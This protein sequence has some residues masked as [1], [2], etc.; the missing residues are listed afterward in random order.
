MKKTAELKTLGVDDYF[1]MQDEGKLRWSV[2]LGIFSSEDAAKNRLEALRA[3]GVRSAQLGERET[4]VAKIWFQVR[5]PDAALQAKL[6]AIAQ[7]LPG[8]EVRNCQ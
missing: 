5:G 8:T 7:G 3:K 4:Q 6:K 1:V 2:S